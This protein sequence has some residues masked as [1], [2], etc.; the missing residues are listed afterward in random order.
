M[1]SIVYNSFMGRGNANRKHLFKESK[2]YKTR[3]SLSPT[4]KGKLIILCGVPGSG[5]S[6][7]TNSLLQKDP[8]VLV[9][10]S[11]S[12]RKEVFASLKEANNSHNPDLS[13]EEIR[14]KNHENNQRIFA[15]FH[16]RI[17][18]GLEENKTVVAD[19]T[20]LNSFSRRKLSLIATDKGS[21]TELALFENSDKALV[22]NKE[23][24]EDAIVPDH[25]MQRMLKDY[26]KSLGQ[27]DS[28]EY[29]SVVKINIEEV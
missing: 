24:D 22:W 17:A 13:E 11:D 7:W 1:G 26:N 18:K 29:D 15:I 16:S 3:N 14:Q 21:K 25:A 27:I 23:R 5:K 8:E 20:N 2:E 4:T 12:I 19:A 10:S 9:V 28:E 6:T